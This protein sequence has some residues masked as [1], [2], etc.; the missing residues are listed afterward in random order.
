MGEQTA[1]RPVDDKPWL[2]W[3]EKFKKMEGKVALLK[4]KAGSSWPS[5]VSR[6]AG[7]DSEL[8]SEEEATELRLHVGLPKTL[9][10]PVQPVCD[11]VVAVDPLNPRQ[12][13]RVV[14][15]RARWRSRAGSN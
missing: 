13:H 4:F 15:G 5:R 11:P 10:T 12:P 8:A 9:L 2:A 1:I 7:S 3:N 14:F 6:L